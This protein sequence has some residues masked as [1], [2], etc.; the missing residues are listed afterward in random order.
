MQRG[1]LVRQK[2]CVDLL[3]GREG[4]TVSPVLPGIYLQTLTFVLGLFWR[5]ELF[6][7]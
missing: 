6:S 7:M 1:C 5:H 4:A 2:G 3:T